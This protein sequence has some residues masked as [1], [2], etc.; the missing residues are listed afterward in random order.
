MQRRKF[1]LYGSTLPLI[2]TLDA[3]S[4]PVAPATVSQQGTAAQSALVGVSKYKPSREDIAARFRYWHAGPLLNQAADLIEQCES[5]L[6]AFQVTA[7][8]ASE[9][10]ILLDAEG[11]DIELMEARRTD[12][13]FRRDIVIGERVQ[14]S[15]QNTDTAFANSLAEAQKLFN[16]EEGQSQGAAGWTRNAITLREKTIAAEER[17]AEKE[18]TAKRLEWSRQDTEYEDR[19]F[20]MRKAEHKERVALTA[21]GQPLAYA[22]RAKLAASRV[23]LTYEQAFARAKA[24]EEGLARV[25]GREADGV[26]PP[27]GSLEEERISH[28]GDWIR[29]ALEWLVQY[30]QLDQAFTRSV[31]LRAVVERQDIGL[32]T[33]LQHAI[34]SFEFAMQI[35]P[36]L[37][38]HVDNVRLRG[39]GASLVGRSGNVPWAMTVSVPTRAVFLRN[40]TSLQAQAAGDT[41]P[42]CLLGR[43][44]NRSSVRPIEQAGMISLMNLSPIGEQS[45]GGRWQF[46]IERPSAS[47]EESFSRLDDIVLDLSCVGRPR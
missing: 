22:W 27:D 46:R 5:A 44:E 39:L 2:T 11:K 30:E 31:A 36:G 21:P 14:Q 47:A 26:T 15:Q 10:R 32:W 18:I 6:R 35:P 3:H 42:S 38:D 8:S 9:L 45:N 23:L 40:G 24:A 33:R 12:G 25:Y 43:V 13:L 20:E 19:K 16:Y 29:Q 34:D 7:I 4:P 17:L 28:V 41:V 37:F 1:L